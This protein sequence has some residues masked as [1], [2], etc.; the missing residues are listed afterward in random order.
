M[1][2]SLGSWPWAKRTGRAMQALYVQDVVKLL[3]DE[4]ERAGSQ[5]EFARQNG[6]APSLI[7]RVLRG[8][9]LPTSR[10]CR[11]LGLEWVLVHRTAPCDSV[12]EVDIVTFQ[13]FIRALRMQ[14]NKA[15]GI[16]AWGRQFGIDRSHLSSVLHKRRA[17]DR[18]IIAA[19]NLAEALVDANNPRLPRSHRTYFTTSRK[20]P[21]ARWE[22]R[23]RISMRG[24]SAHEA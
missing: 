7:S 13:E 12:A 21:H 4:V 9:R 3:R 20:Q 14:I 24:S 22:K 18:R 8:E 15:G 1:T 2:Q 17:P 23:P 6:V 16:A 5:S 19:L 11:A 10:L